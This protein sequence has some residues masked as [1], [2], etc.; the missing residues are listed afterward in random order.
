MLVVRM[1]ILR[2]EDRQVR[3]VDKAEPLDPFACLRRLA[4]ADDHNF[5]WPTLVE[6]HRF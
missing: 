2:D 4:S 5:G 3:N 1:L 6:V